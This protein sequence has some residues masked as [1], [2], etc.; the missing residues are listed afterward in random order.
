[1]TIPELQI[2]SATR[3]EAGNVGPLTNQLT[4]AIDPLGI[5]WEL[6]FVDDSDDET[7]ERISEIANGNPRVRML[8]RRAEGRR[9]GL[10]SALNTGFISSRS[11]IILVIDADLQHPPEVVP[12]L[13]APILTEKADVSVGSRYVD[14][15]SA[16]GLAG[17][18][19]HWV[20]RAATMIVRTMFPRIRRVEDP[21][22]GFFAFRASVIEGVELRPE[23][24]KMLVELLVRGR[25]TNVVEVPFHFAGRSEGVSNVS[26]RLGLYFLRHVGRLWA[27]TTGPSWVR[28]L[29]R[30]NPAHALTPMLNERGETVDPTQLR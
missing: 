18:F 12:A 28:R 17:P 21:V 9:G 16:S 29:S 26:P 15:G 27:E 20:S 7:P 6:L 10:S 5:T 25:S 2:V 24:F 8:H 23:G 13:L 1:M 11:P 30:P 3:H 4:A 19:R 14:G 22:S